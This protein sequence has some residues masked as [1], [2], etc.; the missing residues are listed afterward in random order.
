MQIEILE[1]TVISVLALASFIAAVL[2]SKETV[3]HIKENLYSAAMF[4]I[5]MCVMVCLLYWASL[6]DAAKAKT[7]QQTIGVQK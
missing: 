1:I 6:T 7:A 5:A 3:V 2:A 4:L